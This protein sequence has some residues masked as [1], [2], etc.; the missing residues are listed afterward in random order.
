VSNINKGQPEHPLVPESL[1]EQAERDLEA[2]ARAASGRVAKAVEV[3]DFDGAVKELLNLRVPIDAF[4]DGV[5]VMV[6]DEQVRSARLGLLAFVRKLFLRIADFARVVLEG[7][8][9]GRQAAS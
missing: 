6:D 4:F 2:A 9:S 8:E 1:T 5:M 7:E 3:G